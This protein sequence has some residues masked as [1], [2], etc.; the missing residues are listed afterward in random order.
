MSTKIIDLQSANKAG[1][2]AVS[3]AIAEESGQQIYYATSDFRESINDCLLSY[4]SGD[5]LTDGHIIGELLKR[6]APIAPKDS[7]TYIICPCPCR[8]RFAYV[9]PTKQ[10]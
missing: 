5:L 7:A 3:E 4:K 1:L 6:G 2:Q 9:V 10:V 8:H